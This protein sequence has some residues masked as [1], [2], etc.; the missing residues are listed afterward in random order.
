MP[1]HPPPVGGIGVGSIEQQHA[2]INTDDFVGV[3]NSYNTRERAVV[4]KEPHDRKD[5]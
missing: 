4:T 2:R 1:E 3:S 5:I